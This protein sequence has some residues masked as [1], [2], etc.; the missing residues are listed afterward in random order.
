MKICIE[1]TIYSGSPSQI[2]TQLRALHF[3][4]DTF[5][6]VEGYIRY[7][8]NTIRRMTELPCELPEG[9]TEKRAAALIHVLHEIGALELLEES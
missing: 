9:S 6:G 7:M 1:E 2:L 8:Q 5:A 4:A 3:D